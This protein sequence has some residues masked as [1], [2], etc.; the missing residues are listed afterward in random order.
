MSRNCE[1][2]R[3]QSYL[4]VVVQTKLSLKLIKS[5]DLGDFKV[6]PNDPLMPS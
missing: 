1:L 5:H 4:K 6:D 2:W 3:C